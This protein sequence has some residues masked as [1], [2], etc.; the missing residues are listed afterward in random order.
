MWTD[1]LSGQLERR[2]QRLNRNEGKFDS[3]RVVF[4]DFTFGLPPTTNKI[5]RAFSYQVIVAGPGQ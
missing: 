5:S 2:T 3:A 1:A 4:E